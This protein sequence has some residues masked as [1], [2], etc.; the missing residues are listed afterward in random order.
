MIFYN[1]KFILVEYRTPSDFIVSIW[2]IV[3]IDKS[4]EVF[5]DIVDN[6]I[7]L[8]FCKFKILLD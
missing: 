5:I 6:L 3:N 8:Y 4:F 1:F 7:V 2:V